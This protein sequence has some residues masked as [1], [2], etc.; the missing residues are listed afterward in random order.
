M[1]N[2][3]IDRKN[4]TIRYR[5]DKCD[6]LSV[7][8]FFMTSSREAIQ[9][10][11]TVVH[12]PN[13]RISVLTS[14]HCC[15]PA[16]QTLAEAPNANYFT[17]SFKTV[18]MQ[19]LVALYELFVSLFSGWIYGADFRENYASTGV[20]LLGLISPGIAAHIMNNYVNAIRLGPSPLEAKLHEIELLEDRSKSLFKFIASFMGKK[21]V[22]ANGPQ[23][24][25]EE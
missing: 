13:S 9:I 10:A 16:S 18:V 24:A 17:L 21:S 6:I 14:M 15:F 7:L 20:R 22:P 3:F 2:V 8:P 4:L 11:L 23:N 19:R 1:D 5:V 25:H 12:N